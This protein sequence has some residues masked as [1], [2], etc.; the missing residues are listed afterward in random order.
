M[1]KQRSITARNGIPLITSNSTNN[2][3][4]GQEESFHYR[5]F[6]LC[7][8]RTIVSEPSLLGCKTI[9]RVSIYFISF[10][11]MVIHYVWPDHW[12]RDD[13]LCV[14]VR[15]VICVC[16]MVIIHYPMTAS[17]SWPDRRVQPPSFT[18]LRL[19]SKSI[20]CTT[21]V[22]RLVG[23]T[24]PQK[25]E[26]PATNTKPLK[27]NGW[28]IFHP[29]WCCVLLNWVDPSTEREP[30]VLWTYH[31][32]YPFKRMYLIYELWL[33]ESP[34]CHQPTNRTHHARAGSLWSNE[35]DEW[36]T[37]CAVLRRR[38]GASTAVRDSV[39]V[40][41]LNELHER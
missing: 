23:R 19:E 35:M 36:D 40:C 41:D 25:T 7:N 39:C 33:H 28:G 4:N 30:P 8:C 20:S 21:S 22:G 13:M 16:A 24:G 14:C 6:F 27:Q 29:F 2:P 11:L 1:R 10:R 9:V 38:R 32:D 3:I 26:K 12:I 15:G 17:A 34:L 5:I 31:G 18:Q 37:Y